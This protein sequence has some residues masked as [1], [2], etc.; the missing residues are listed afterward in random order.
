MTVP[1]RSIPDATREILMKEGNDKQLQHVPEPVAYAY[2]H[3]D[4]QIGIDATLQRF[5]CIFDSPSA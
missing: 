1:Q 3:Y 2:R 4:G 5:L